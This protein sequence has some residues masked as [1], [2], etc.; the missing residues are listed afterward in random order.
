MKKAILFI[1]ISLLIFYFFESTSHKNYTKEEQIKLWERVKSGD[2]DATNKLLLYYTT[3][4]FKKNSQKIVKLQRIGLDKDNDFSCYL[5]GKSL[6]QNF[7]RNSDEVK[8]GLI[9]LKHAR[10]MGNEKAQILLTKYEF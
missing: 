6:V 3:H 2:K 5:F 9:W 8:E 1:G 7:P 4:N 10:R